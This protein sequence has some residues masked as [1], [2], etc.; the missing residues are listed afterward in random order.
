[1]GVKTGAVHARFYRGAA[2]ARVEP[3]HDE[4]ESVAPILGVALFE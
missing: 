4:A 3:A 1:M 2:D